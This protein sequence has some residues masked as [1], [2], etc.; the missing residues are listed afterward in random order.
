MWGCLLFKISNAKHLKTTKIT[1]RDCKS[2]FLQ[3][4]Y[5]KIDTYYYQKFFLYRQTNCRHLSRLRNFGDDIAAD[6][7]ICNRQAILFAWL[8]AVR[9]RCN[10][11]RELKLTM[12][13]YLVLAR[14][15]IDIFKAAEIINIWGPRR[16]QQRKLSS[17]CYIFM[18]SQIYFWI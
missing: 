12:H 13:R 11:T 17:P 4:L 6:S 8:D 7:V 16:T 18:I 10:I 3:L 5:L 15:E 2:Q 14:W 9:L 1:R